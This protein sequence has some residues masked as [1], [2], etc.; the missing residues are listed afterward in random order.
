MSRKERKTT[1]INTIKLQKQLQIK[2]RSHQTRANRNVKC[3]RRTSTV[4][5][6]FYSSDVQWILGGIG[7]SVT[8]I[9]CPRWFSGYDTCP[10]SGRPG[11]DPPLRYTIFF[12]ITSLIQPA[13]TFGGQCDLQAWHAWEHAFSLEEWMWQWSGVLGGLVVVMLAWIVGDWGSIPHWG[14]QVF[15]ITSLV[16]PTV[17]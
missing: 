17:T 9:R 6:D 2:T 12:R 1:I 3:L 7:M 15:Q 11:F 14:T 10:D 16:R 13:V 4:K 8:A 5:F